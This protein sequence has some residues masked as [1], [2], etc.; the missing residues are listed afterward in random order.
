MFFEKGGD[1]ITLLT[2]ID[3]S[4]T[5]SKK[6]FFKKNGDFLKFNFA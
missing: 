2:I 4:L 5:L 1:C 3:V 6:H